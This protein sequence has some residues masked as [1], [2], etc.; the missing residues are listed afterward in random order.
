MKKYQITG[1]LLIFLAFSFTACRDEE[2][3]EFSTSTVQKE[4][5]PTEPGE[6][7][8]ETDTS[9]TERICVYV[10]GEVE[11]AGVYTLSADARVCD[12]INAAGGMTEEAAEDYWN[13]AELLTDG[14]MIYVPTEEEAAQRQEEGTS[15]TTSTGADEQGRINLNTATKEQLMTI[16]GIGEARA[17]AIISYR[18]KNGNFASVDEITGVSGIG[19]AMLESMRDAVTVD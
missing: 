10:C 11:S 14:E 3:I 9:L 2:Q 7:E 19:E 12:A 15:E 6:P 1:L 4:S 8:A 17:E 16:S 5:E 13:L 18:E